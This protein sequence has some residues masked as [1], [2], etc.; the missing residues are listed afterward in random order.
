MCRR[1]SGR[2][3]IKRIVADPPGWNGDANLLGDKHNRGSGLYALS[4]IVGDL[5]VTFSGTRRLE[6]QHATSF[7]FR[8]RQERVETDFG[9]GLLAVGICATRIILAWVMKRKGGAGA[10][11]TY[12]REFAATGRQRG[13]ERGG[14]TPA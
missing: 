5:E 7:D 14:P 4:Q 2:Q 8:L 11:R 6:G 1:T 13:A 10:D 3:F 12:G 9:L